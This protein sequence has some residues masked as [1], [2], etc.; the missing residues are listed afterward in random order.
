MALPAFYRGLAQ[1]ERAGLTAGDALARLRD[2]GTLKLPGVAEAVRGGDSLADALARH[3]REVPAEDVEL[4]RAGEETGRLGEC[5]ER[6]ASIHEER[7][8][9]WASFRSKLRYP[10]LV[11]HVAALCIPIGLTAMKGWE[12]WTIGILAV[13]WGLIGAV[14]WVRRTP[15]GRARIRTLVDALPLFGAAARRQRHAVFASVLAAAHD[16]GVTLDRG[17]GLAGRA[18]H[19]DRATGAAPAVAAGTPLGPALGTARALPAELVARITTA[20]HAGELSPELE[21]IAAEEA[22]AAEHALDRAVE[23]TTKGFYV[24]LALVV[25]VYALTILSHAYSV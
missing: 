16:A 9:M 14:A 21:R 7:A 3:P 13:A 18:A 5:L 15:A 1:L 17:T 12:I 25:L 23:Y 11:F 8:R 2:A 20:E 10:L 4:V 22:E 19:L 24:L 6:L